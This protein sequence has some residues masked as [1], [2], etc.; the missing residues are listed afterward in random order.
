MRPSRA[1]TAVFGING[2]DSV[3]NQGSIGGG[4][5][6]VW[7]SGGAGTVTNQGLMT[8]GSRGVY[9][10]GGAGAVSNQGTIQNT[11]PFTTQTVAF[12]GVLLVAG[13]SINNA[14][15]EATGQQQVVRL[16]QAMSTS[17]PWCMARRVLS[18]TP[19]P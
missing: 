8:G 6:G 12:G 16:T 3:G 1:R 5:V 4:Y 13:G 7:L 11:I 9:I 15:S 14:A 10:A 2:A 18:P 17:P 19:A